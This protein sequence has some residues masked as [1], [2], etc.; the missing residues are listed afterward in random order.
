VWDPFSLV[1]GLLVWLHNCFLQVLFYSD[2]TAKI[3]TGDN[4]WDAVC[5]ARSI[6]SLRFSVDMA[7]I[8]P[9]AKTGLNVN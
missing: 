6:Y 9:S 3:V 5:L 1:A 4:F 8:M 2:C 7:E